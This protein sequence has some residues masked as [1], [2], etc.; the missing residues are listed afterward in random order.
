M[1][2]NPQPISLRL[3]E[4][5]QTLLAKNL[6][7]ARMAAGVTQHALAASSDISRATIAQLE[8][9]CGD[10]RL[11]TMSALAA[12]LGIPPYVLLMGVAE[13]AALLALPEKL[14][15]PV[16]VVSAI[17]LREM[18]H[19]VGSGMLKDRIRAGRL[20]AQIAQEAAGA[21]VDAGAVVGA[22]IFSA[23]SPGVG[24]VAGAALGAGGLTEGEF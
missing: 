16:F 11:S 2:A 1:S 9:G 4:S 7:V 24:T 22:A 10:P 23:I 18:N 3:I 20:R 17:D 21:S 13:V 8:T 12:A 19:F 6:T 5:P 15:R 14:A